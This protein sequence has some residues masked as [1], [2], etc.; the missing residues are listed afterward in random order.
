[1]GGGGGGGG[2]RPNGK[3]TALTAFFLFVCLFCVVLNLLSE[4]FQWFYFRGSIIVRGSNFFQE[5]G[6]GGVSKC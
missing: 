2:S 5:W 1:M 3:K 6:G 4:G